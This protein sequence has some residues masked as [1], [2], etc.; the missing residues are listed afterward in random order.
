MPFA[1]RFCIAQSGAVVRIYGKAWNLRREE[2]EWARRSRQSA[3]RRVLGIFLP[4]GAAF[5]WTRYKARR[6][7]TANS[8]SGFSLEDRV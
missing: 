3:C 1:K 8:V 5:G 7:I 2:G 4:E 6:A